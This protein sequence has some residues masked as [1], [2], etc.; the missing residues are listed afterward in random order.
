MPGTAAVVGA[1]VF[2]VTSAIELANRGWQVTLLDPGP[3]PHPLAASTDISK[4]IRA[5]Y[6]DDEHY[7][8][9]ME[10]A[11]PVWR[12]WNREWGTDLYH[13]TGFLV[14]AAGPMEAGRFEHTSYGVLAGRGYPVE[15]LASDDIT[16]R[17]PLW[18]PPTGVEGYL[19][20]VAGWAES[21]AVVQH[22]LDAARDIGVEIRTGQTAELLIEE[23]RVI[24]VRVGSQDTIERDATVVA[25]GA[26]TVGLVP[27]TD[28]LITTTGQPVIHFQPEQPDRFSSPAFPPWAADIGTIGWYGFPATRSGLVKVANHGAGRILP[29][30]AERR[31]GDGWEQLF[32]AF[33]TDW[34]PGLAD[35]PIAGDRLCLYTDT[36]DGDF[37]IDRHPALAGL[38]V[39][40]GGSGHG[41]KFA[42]VLGPLVADAVEEQDN[43]F[44]HRFR[45][46]APTEARTEAARG[47]GPRPG[48]G[49]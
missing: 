48:A 5:D 49:L 4:M 20:P 42:P 16:S 41:F 24:G 22:L 7:I 17:F 8:Q 32:R 36:T 28:D 30:N 11:F 29:P 35:A 39:A 9:L 44:A 14:L 3:V 15:P 37:L 23:S 38:V 34:I 1:G 27:S 21:G 46:R 43:P 40:T 31:V 13:E 33:L 25:A 26:W 45:W 19:S 12:R 18:R 2:G 6:G 47:T 10:K